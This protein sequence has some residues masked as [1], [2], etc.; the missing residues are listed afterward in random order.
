MSI[1]IACLGVLGLSSYISY[2][3]TKEIGIRKVNGARIYEILILLNKD[4]ITWITV[5]FIIA[6]SISWY[7]TKMW[8]EKFAYKIDMNWWVF[9][10]GGLIA[11]AIALI[12]V[13]WQSWKAAIRNPVES[14][15]YE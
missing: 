14:L 7:V 11:L 2:K 12:S 4:I 15:R 8:L 5:A 9:A 1:I 10:L 13:S 3:R 6:C